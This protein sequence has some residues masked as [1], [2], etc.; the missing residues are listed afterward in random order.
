MH[1]Q[2][3]NI[4]QTQIGPIHFVGI[5]GIG[6]S[7]IAEILHALGYEVQG[8]DVSESYVTDRLKTIGI[9][10][11]LPHEAKNVENCSLVVKSTAIKNDNPE[12]IRAIELGI[13]IIKR[14]EMLAEIMRFKHSIAISGTHGKTTTTSLVAHLLDMAGLDPT[15]INGGIINHKK[16]NAYVGSGPYLVAEADES[17]GT[18][19]KVPS[20]V[21]VITNIDPEHLDYYHTFEAAIAAYRTFITSIPFYGFSVLCY[22]HPIVREL[23]KSIKERRVISYGISSVGV[24]LKATNIK[25]DMNGSVFDV[26]ISECYA[27]AKGLKNKVI[28]GVKLSL[29]GEHNI[30]NALSA[31]AIGIELGIS[32][33]VIINA[34]SNFE[35]VK[36]RFTKTGEV[37]GVTIIDDYA[38]HPVEI[39]ATLKTAKEVVREQGNKVIA[40]MQPHRYSRLSELMDEFSASFEYA[41]ELIISDVYGAGEEPISGVTSKELIKRIKANTKRDAIHLRD[42]KELPGIINNL[43]KSGDIVVLL[44]AGDITKWAYELPINLKE[45]QKLAS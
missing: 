4:F 2:L 13:P 27:K 6:M 26:E 16:T 20:Y 10:V 11:S 38:H 33:D 8:S 45:L 14:S 25:I 1:N 24:D 21:S 30:A 41:D 15:V 23:G 22:D 19:I 3:T 9:K 43:A 36:R 39:I 40:V 29:K 5:G 35:G 42:R 28:K 12:I 32:Q 18:F 7:G 37:S 34:F 31:I 17:D 44:G